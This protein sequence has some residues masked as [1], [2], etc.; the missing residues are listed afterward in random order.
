VFALIDIRSIV[1]KHYV[2]LQRD[3]KKR[4]IVLIFFIMPA[5][6]S[7]LL[8][9]KNKF[10]TENSVNA[11]ITAFTLFVGFLLSI[12]FILF[13]IIRDIDN[14]TERGKLRK[15]LLDHLYSNSLYAL[16]ISIL[17]LIVLLFTAVTDVW[18]KTDTTGSQSLIQN[19]STNQSIEIAKNLDIVGGDILLTILSFVSY[20]LII[21]FLMTLLM[22]LKRL[23]I[24]LTS[25]LDEQQNH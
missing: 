17:T 16:L 14:S 6:F 13:D 18:P 10:L 7:L 24:L 2:T 8:I 9:L 12:I 19:I 25:Q 4:F 3:A 1:S 20:F 23:S 22:I 21:H 15:T 11:L 5:T